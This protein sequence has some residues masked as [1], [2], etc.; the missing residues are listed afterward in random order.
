MFKVVSKMFEQL[1]LTAK[2][3]YLLALSNSMFNSYVA[4]LAMV[5]NLFLDFTVHFDNFVAFEDGW[6]ENTTKILVF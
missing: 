1:H 4:I 5:T 6:L 2:I 3:F